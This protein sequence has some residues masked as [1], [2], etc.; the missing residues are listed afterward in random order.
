VFSKNN[1]DDG[2]DDSDDWLW[3]TV[4]YHSGTSG[5]A[6]QLTTDDDLSRATLSRDFAPMTRRDLA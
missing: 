3:P 2:D 6:A 4:T 5:L 1:D